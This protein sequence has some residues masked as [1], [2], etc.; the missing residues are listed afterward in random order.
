MVKIKYNLSVEE[1]T[2]LKF[3]EDITMAAIQS[4]LE[5][6]YDL[7]MSILGTAGVDVSKF[8]PDLFPAK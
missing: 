2:K 4:I 5:W 1:T 8:N 7:V 6:I 3:M